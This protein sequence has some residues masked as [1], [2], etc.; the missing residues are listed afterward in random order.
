MLNSFTKGR[1]LGLIALMLTGSFALA[2]QPWYLVTMSPNEE[3]VTL[4][5][6]DGY[7]AY[8][9]ISP[10][11]LVCLAAMVTAAI[12]AGAARTV[13][14]WVGVL[15]SAALTLFSA[16]SI[17]QQDLSGV[18]KEI[19]N[20][21]G[22]AATHGVTGLEIATQPLAPATVGVFGLLCLVFGLVIFSSRNWKVSPVKATRQSHRKPK[23]SI[24]LWDEQR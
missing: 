13:S 7:S 4:K 23:D 8:A 18:S 2:G 15:S 16:L 20:A 21:T 22:I 19:E 24:S 1:S 11:L 5:D 17:S 3:T 10:L 6:F 14:L 9:W 12:S